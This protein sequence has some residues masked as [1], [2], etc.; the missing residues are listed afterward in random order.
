MFTPSVDSKHNPLGFLT[1]VDAL[2]EGDVTRT[3]SV[4][5]SLLYDVMVHL[6]QTAIKAIE[7]KEQLNKHK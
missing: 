6:E 3:E 2:T 4:R 7:M 5:K 1:L